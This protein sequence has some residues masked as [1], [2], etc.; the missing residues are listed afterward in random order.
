MAKRW[1]CWRALR[2][3]A[4]PAA[5]LG[6]F[7]AVRTPEP[8]RTAFALVAGV[9]NT[10]SPRARAR[11]LD[12]FVAEYVNLQI[13]DEHGWTQRRLRRDELS[14]QLDEILMGHPRCQLELEVSAVSAVGSSEQLAGK[15]QFSESQAGDLHAESRGVVVLFET[16]RGERR[17]ASVVLSA[18][19]RSLPEARP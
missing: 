9:C 6:G 13:E 3:A 12:A 15:L 8:A 19:A 7:F 1:R 17:L 4:L 14:E 2:W 16:V 10:S 11:L 5:L 18:R